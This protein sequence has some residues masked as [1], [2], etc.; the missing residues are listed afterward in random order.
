MFLTQPHSE[1]HQW[2]IS[3]GK[4]AHFWSSLMGTNVFFTVSLV[5]PFYFTFTLRPS[6]DLRESPNEAEVVASE[7]TLLPSYKKS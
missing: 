1:C 6:S 4:W 3:E 2:L 7:K 5:L